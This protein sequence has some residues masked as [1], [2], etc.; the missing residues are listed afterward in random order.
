[1]LFFAYHD[2]Q[3]VYTPSI[4][5]QGMLSLGNESLMCDKQIFLPISSQP[6]PI[7]LS[8]LLRFRAPKQSLLTEKLKLDSIHK[9]KEAWRHK[10]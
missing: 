7:L 1:M 5:D 2:N 4:P 6:F 9:A 3:T 8:L 10:D